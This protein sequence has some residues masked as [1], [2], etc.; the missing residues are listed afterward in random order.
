LLSD[1]V[2]GDRPATL[3]VIHR[4][5]AWHFNDARRSNRPRLKWLNR[6]FTSAAVLLLAETGALLVALWRVHS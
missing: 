2:E 6:A 4:S 1:Y 5:L 3:A